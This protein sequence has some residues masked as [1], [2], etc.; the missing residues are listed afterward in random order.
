MEK[1]IMTTP[2]PTTIGMLLTAITGLGS[3]I[4]VLWRQ[5]TRHLQVI[6][7]KLSDCE[8]DRLALWRQLARQAGTDI[9]DL[10]NQDD[11]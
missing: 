11:K 9:E 10:K 8:S 6:E 1:A 5:V 4:G 3:A 7:S 2:D